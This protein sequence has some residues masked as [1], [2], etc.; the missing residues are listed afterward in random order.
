MD[1]RLWNRLLRMAEAEVRSVLDALPGP[2]R[3]KTRPLPIRFED[4]PGPELIDDGIEPDLMGLLWG[5]AYGEVEPS[6][7]PAQ[8]F[9]FLQNIWEGAGEDPAEYRVQVRD[10]LLHEIGH[11]LGLDEDGLADRGLE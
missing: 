3:E 6:G 7:V 11:Y 4:V 1:K 10:T 2:L 5:D 9:L 8:I